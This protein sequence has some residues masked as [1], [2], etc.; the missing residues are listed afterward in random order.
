MLIQN[1]GLLPVTWSPMLT[2]GTG[3]NEVCTSCT[4]P[5]GMKSHN[6]GVKLT[7]QSLVQAPS[8]YAPPRGHDGAAASGGNAVALGGINLGPGPD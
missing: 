1:A 4:V 5:T 2:R 7:F 8:G 6:S 3:T